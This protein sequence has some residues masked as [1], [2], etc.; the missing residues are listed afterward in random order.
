M[1]TGRRA[2]R[3]TRGCSV[4]VDFFVGLVVV[5]LGLLG[6]ASADSGELRSSGAPPSCIGFVTRS[7]T[8][9]IAAAA[10]PNPRPDP[11]PARGPPTLP[12]TRQRGLARPGA[13]TASHHVARARRRRPRVATARDARRPPRPPPPRASPTPCTHAPHQPRDDGPATRLSFLRRVSVRSAARRARRPT[14]PPPPSSSSASSSVVFFC[15]EPY[16]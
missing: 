11:A 5:L 2:G 8:A 3:R 7:L 4:A 16:F 6:A 1:G 9:A 12:L 10:L 14:L 15:L 13:S